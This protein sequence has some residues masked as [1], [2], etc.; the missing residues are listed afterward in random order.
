LVREWPSI[1]YDVSA[2]TGHRSST[3]TYLLSAG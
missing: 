3:K 1:P 2:V